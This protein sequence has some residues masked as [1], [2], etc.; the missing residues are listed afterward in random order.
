MLLLMGALGLYRKLDRENVGEF[1]AETIPATGHLLLVV[2]VV[3]WGQQLAFPQTQSEIKLV[4]FAYRRSSR[5]RTHC[6]P[7]GFLWG[8]LCHYSTLKSRCWLDRSWLLSGS[9][10]G[11]VGSCPRRS[12]IF[13]LSKKT[14][15]QFCRSTLTKN[16]VEAWHVPNLSELYFLFLDIEHIQLLLVIV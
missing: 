4:W 3:R 7:C 8:H 5:A 11:H 14:Q 12:P 10:T 13:R 9:S 1:G 15:F 16:F 6:A 2:I